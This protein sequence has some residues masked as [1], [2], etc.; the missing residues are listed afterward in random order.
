MNKLLK[1]K[2]VSNVDL[3]NWLNVHPQTI[4]NHKIDNWMKL[5]ISQVEI[6][7]KKLGV[8]CKELVDVIIK[9]K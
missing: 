5:N 8:D 1:D 9:N 7:S 2:K 4:S 6:I 3:A